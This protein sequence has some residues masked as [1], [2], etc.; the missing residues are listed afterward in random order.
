MLMSALAGA[1]GLFLLLQS[2]VLFATTLRLTEPHP[3]DERPSPGAVFAICVPI[4]AAEY[5]L[6]AMFLP[7]V[8]AVIPNAAFVLTGTMG[9]LSL[10]CGLRVWKQHKAVYRWY[11]MAFFVAM[12]LLGFV[13]W[14]WSQFEA[15]RMALQE[16][17][18]AW[19]P[20]KVT[21]VLRC[22]QMLLAAAVGQ[23]ILSLW[24]KRWAQAAAVGGFVC[25]M[26][27]IKQSIETYES[28][29]IST[30]A[31]GFWLWAAG[32]MWLLMFL[33]VA[34]TEYRARREIWH[35]AR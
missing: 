22:L 34:V 8:S 13:A 4:G 30:R 35:T 17:G 7:D 24:G 2:G 1:V 26:L 16:I 9:T 11:A 29:H 31:D 27:W 33:I 28:T 5:L 19:A 14:E 23:L 6:T 3:R 15:Q 12:I 32:A 10:A 25:L 20:L 21:E 18:G